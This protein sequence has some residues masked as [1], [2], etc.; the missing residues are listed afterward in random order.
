M[1]GVITINSDALLNA[2]KPKLLQMPEVTRQQYNYIVYTD[3]TKYYAKNGATGQ[4]DF[5]D[6]DA[7]AVLQAVLDAMDGGELVIASD[8]PNTTL[9]VSGKQYLAVRF[10]K[11]GRIEVYSSDNVFLQ[12][13]EVKN[14]VLI[15]D[16]YRC[17]LMARHIQGSSTVPG[18]ELRGV[19]AYCG[20]HFILVNTVATAP[21][22]G[23][24]AG[25]GILL[26]P[27]NPS[28]TIEGNTVIV[29]GT[30]YGS[31]TGVYLKAGSHWN[32]V[33]CDVDNA[34]ANG[35]NSVVIDS[36][37]YN[38]I[39]FLYGFASKRPVVKGKGS[40]VITQA[41]Y[42]VIPDTWLDTLDTNGFYEHSSPWWAQWTFVDPSGYRK[43]VHINVDGFINLFKHPS[44]P[45]PARLLF[46]NDLFTRMSRYMS[47]DYD[48]STDTLTV[49]GTGKLRVN[50]I[51]F[52]GQTVSVG[53]DST[54]TIPA[55]VYYASLGP[56][57]RA[58]V[59]NP[60]TA[61]WETVIAAGGKGYVVSD[62]SN[63]RLYNAGT[64]TENSYLVRVL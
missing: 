57:T 8:L 10:R 16:S 29:A 11:I 52:D 3:G 37:A 6:S 9:L 44:L 53:A 46:S 61:A 2:I 5:S 39:V 41:L 40:K 33:F 35:S 20:W 32:R 58:E 24:A 31:D 26:N 15:Q 48:R 14:G 27:T 21:Y 28:Y 59:Y 60:Q 50:A 62:G 25:T 49:A 19:N 38:N 36:G 4:V 17:T 51:K 18:I 54:H 23:P 43:G 34:P 42:D 55:G 47:L 56:N 12:G 7:S 1:S 22:G 63:A 64:A 13:E 45:G 30:I